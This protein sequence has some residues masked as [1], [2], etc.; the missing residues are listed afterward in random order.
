MVNKLIQSFN[1]EE[2]NTEISS[3]EDSKD[4]TFEDYI[5]QTTLEEIDKIDAALPA[6]RDLSASDKEFDEIAEMAIKSHKDLTD[7]GFN[8]ETRFAG[9][10][11]GVAGNM[12]GHALTAKKNKVEKKLK[13]IE[14]QLK[15][16]RLDQ[17][18]KEL[19]Y[20]IK[21]SNDGSDATIIE[22]ESTSI[23]ISRSELLRELLAKTSK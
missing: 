13:T 2:E 6:I 3:S 20:K 7:L 15:K 10:I 14:L 5:K 23:T 11:L 18:Q 16:M 19:D 12:L 21:N 1:L 4:T 17:Q 8:V 9:E 22:G